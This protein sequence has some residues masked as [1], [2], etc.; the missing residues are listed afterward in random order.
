[1]K[2]EVLHVVIAALLLLVS[3]SDEQQ[4]ISPPKPKP[5]SMS[6]MVSPRVTEF[7]QSAAVVLSLTNDSQEEVSLDFQCHD[8]FGYVIE[9]QSGTFILRNIQECI[10]DPHALVLAAGETRTF[11][12]GIL[13]TLAP[14]N[15]RV[16][17]GMIEYTKEY[18][19]VSNTFFVVPIGSSPH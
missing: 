13:A 6:V 8:P 12:M 16:S 4:T 15:Y 19:W 2:S 18:P 17:A 3:C 11:D 1:M 14:D 10:D 7:M 5:I 9:S